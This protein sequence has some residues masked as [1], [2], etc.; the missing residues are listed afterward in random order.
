MTPGDMEVNAQVRD[1]IARMFKLSPSV[2]ERVITTYREMCWALHQ[3]DFEW[4]AVSHMCGAGFSVHVFQAEG[5]RIT[6]QLETSVRSAVTI[7]GYRGR[8]FEHFA[9]ARA[10]ELLDMKVTDR[11]NNVETLKTRTPAENLI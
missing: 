2:V 7:Y 10:A 9:E 11:D 8:V 6:R 4:T 1:A 3:D 5:T